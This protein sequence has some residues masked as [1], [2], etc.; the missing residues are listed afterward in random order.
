MF[1]PS[2]ADAEPTA[3]E[4]ARIERL[5]LERQKQMALRQAKLNR[6]NDSIAEAGPD[7]MMKDYKPLAGSEN[8]A[9]KG[10]DDKKKRWSADVN[11]K[12]K[13][14]DSKG[15]V[16]IV[17]ADGSIRKFPADQPVDLA[18]G[19]WIYTNR[20]SRIKLHYEFENEGKDIIVGQNSFVNIVTD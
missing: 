8:L 5:D 12:C 1:A 2:K 16:R 7:K 17:R 4:R 3:A 14:T 6:Y 11:F 15:D 19:D 18:P 20:D 10:L 13:I 9:Y